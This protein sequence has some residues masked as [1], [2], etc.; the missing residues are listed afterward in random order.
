MN[1]FDAVKAT[2]AI[3][4]AGQATQSAVHAATL[5]AQQDDRP[6]SALDIDT[7]VR[8]KPKRLPIFDDASANAALEQARRGF[9]SGSYLE[10]IDLYEQLME[11]IPAQAA[12][13]L[14]ELYDQ[15]QRL[16]NSE[17]R[18]TLYVARHY[19]FNIL[20]GDKVL[21]IG[22]GHD[23]FPYATH[24]ADI[25]PN[26]N[27]FGRAGQPIKRLD[28]KPFYE[29]GVEKMP[30]AD[31]EFDFVYCSHV[32]EHT[33]NPEIACQE[34]MRVAKRGY[35][36][37]PTRGKDFWL[38]TAKISNHRWSV[39]KFRGNLVFTEY[40]EED[41][42][43]IASNILMDMHCGPQTIREKAFSALVLLRALA[44]N[45][46]LYWEGCFDYEVRR[47]R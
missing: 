47:L 32:L 40:S 44:V 27:H 14:A 15:Y 36:E 17:N 20:P 43:G 3:V 23:P 41:R 4:S 16:P 12:N 11:S 34:L 7:K 6:S 9:L 26:D 24:L 46:C 8:R 19:D 35:I 29:C 10:S 30:F 25:A 28:S 2:Q 31:K 39:E 42:E 1:A 37:T 5:V 22:S 33:V 38:N 18:Y 21:D 45:T 13:I